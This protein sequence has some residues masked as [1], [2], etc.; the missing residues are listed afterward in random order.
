[1][2]M[3]LPGILLSLQIL[4][5]QACP[6][7]GSLESCP[8]D[9]CNL[10]EACREDTRE[11]SL[12]LLQRRSAK[13]SGAKFPK[14]PAF[15]ALITEHTQTFAQFPGE[16]ASDPHYSG[17]TMWYDPA[18]AG[19]GSVMVELHFH[20]YSWVSPKFADLWTKQVCIEEEC[21]YLD[22]NGT[23][24]GHSVNSYLGAW[25]QLLYQQM[26]LTGR[27]EGA[28]EVGG[29]ACDLW[30]VQNSSVGNLSVCLGPDFVPRSLVVEPA[31][32]TSGWSNV[33]EWGHN[34]T[35]HDIQLGKIGVLEQLKVEADTVSPTQLPTPCASPGGIKSMQV[36]R[37]SSPPEKLGYLEDR[38]TF[39]WVGQ[40]VTLGSP[41]R[42]KFAFKKYL[43]VFDVD[44]NGYF[45]IWRDCNY[46][47]DLK[48]YVCPRGKKSNMP[49]TAVTRSSA[50][51]LSGKVNMGM[52]EENIDVGSWLTFPH[53][54][55]CG[56]HAMVG[57][58]GCT[59]KQKASK[60]IFMECMAL[61]NSSG[62]RRTWD[63]DYERAPFPHVLA[64]VKAAVESCP[65]V[66]EPEIKGDAD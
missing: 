60:V 10:G 64:H 13:L 51:Q 41:R 61:F 30:T 32:D 49:D 7:D 6:A 43:Q 45:S 19:L 36:L 48:K 57:D 66:R 40:G 20:T 50:E 56:D 9:Q 12:S 38:D 11:V 31:G 22:R 47:K 24:S 14:M 1:M 3:T 42:I 33:K 5:V 44:F 25:F 21:T 8:A 29:Q 37:A 52:C 4:T 2:C 63:L 46:H 55:K 34:L 26:P 65:D 18:G 53:E 58:D 39:D 16:A 17:G 15:F 54:G 62:W 35:F 59:W 28:S 27:Q 23:S